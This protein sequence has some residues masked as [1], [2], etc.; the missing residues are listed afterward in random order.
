MFRS[1]RPQITRIGAALVAGS[2]LVSTA[3]G[4]VVAQTGS[5]PPSGT[6]VAS[7][8]PSAT[9][10]G[11][12]GPVMTALTLPDGLPAGELYSVIAG[13]PGFIAVGV[14]RPD[15]GGSFQP[16]ILT[17]ADGVAWATVDLGGVGSP[18][19]LNDVVAFP[20]GYAAVGGGGGPDGTDAVALVSAD[21]LGWQ[22]AKDRDL[23]GTQ[24]VG[25]TAWA[26]GL[27]A[28]GCT[29]N[30]LCAPIGFTS[31][32]GLAWTRVP[33]PGEFAPDSV[34][35]A[36]GLL[37]VVGRSGIAD[38]SGP[39]ISTTTDL[40]RWTE[41]AMKFGGSLGEAEVQ[42]KHIVVAGGLEDFLTGA[43]N[44]VVVYSPDGGKRWV[45]LPDTTPPDSWF[46]G[47]STA[48]PTIAFGWQ[49]T[50]DGVRHPAAWI[51]RVGADWQR[52]RPAAGAKGEGMIHDFV[53]PAGG[54]GGIAVGETGSAAVAPAIW[55]IDLTGG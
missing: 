54:S 47:I 11:S 5:P 7:P 24:L 36:D 41:R 31:P 35:A 17:S 18:G 29:G 8:A 27:F 9:A 10:P 21:G 23:K 49:T 2:L 46:E 55:R 48:G 34:V 28:V 32:D 4:P 33:V 53:S 37:V 52:V 14:G 6:E 30:D 19:A 39:V 38:E 16:S 40:A 43:S 12:T 25:V 3:V 51:T 50:A 13:G 44:G 26:D 15:D 20:G 1:T 45:Q 42:G 22:A